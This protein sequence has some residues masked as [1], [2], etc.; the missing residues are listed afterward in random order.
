MER[1]LYSIA[2]WRF[3]DSYHYFFYN[4]EGECLA[5]FISNKWDLYES[6]YVTNISP[7]IQV[8]CITVQCS[9]VFAKMDKVDPVWIER[10]TPVKTAWLQRND[11]SQLWKQEFENL[12]ELQ[13][14]EHYDYGSIA[15]YPVDSDSFGDILEK[16][17]EANTILER[18]KKVLFK[19]GERDRK[20]TSFLCYP[21]KK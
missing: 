17:R 11:N 7:N 16:H 19:P 9:H 4:K 18:A 8:A 3:I 21:W 1:T 6:N 5:D 2:V 10:I 14:V 12:Q 13:S 15:F 20:L